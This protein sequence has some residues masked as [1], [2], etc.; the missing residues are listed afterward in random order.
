MTNMQQLHDALMAQRPAGASHDENCPLCAARNS[1]APEGGNVET[2]T[3]E[4]VE[5]VV[6]EATAS[7]TARLAAMET[8]A[9]ESAV[10]ARIAAFK[11]E[12]E[13][14]IAE[15]R[16]QLDTAVLEAGQARGELDATV[17]YLHE[18]AESE[19]QR[20]ASAARKDERVSRVR[21]VASFPDE[22]LDANADRFAAMSDED[23]ENRIA[24]WASLTSKTVTHEGGIPKHTAL[25]AAR[26][27]SNP[28]QGGMAL[29]REVMQGF[30]NNHVDPR[31]L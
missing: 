28:N 15:V 6:A 31:S 1:G 7:L 3:A 23:F 12:A 2:Y 19:V 14:E 10:E 11:A 18:V 17:A 8:A 29:L 27:I 25:V 9:T 13:A 4:E 22:Y 21:E 24:E 26:E 5:A 20:A 16:T 30:R